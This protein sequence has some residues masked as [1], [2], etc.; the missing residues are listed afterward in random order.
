MSQRPLVLV[1]V[2]GCCYNHQRM[3]SHMKLFGF[4][5]N[6]LL[7]IVFFVYVF[8]QMKRSYHRLMPRLLIYTGCLI[9]GLAGLLISKYLDLNILRGQSEL[10]EPLASR[11]VL[12]IAYL[13]IATAMV[14]VVSMVRILR[15]RSLPLWFRGFVL[16]SLLLIFTAV[17]GDVLLR[18]GT[19]FHRL[20]AEVL[21][22]YALLFFI[23]EIS[24]LFRLLWNP[25]AGGGKTGW[26]KPARL[27][28][29]IFLSRY[30]FIL[31]LIWISPPA[32]RGFLMVLVL[33][34]SSFIWFKF[35]LLPHM[36]ELKIQGTREGMVVDLAREYSLS[37]RETEILALMLAGKN[38]REIEDEL[39]IS[40]NT[41]KNHVYSIYKKT[42]A[43][44]RFHL[45][46]LVRE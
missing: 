19:V 3:I 32:I 20:M 16:G 39:F 13:I 21:E 30:L 25:G 33:H 24:F 35:V 45:F 38:N 28:A 44:N 43:R 10:L 15:M 2:S 41:V 11:L 18:Q 40:Y 14:S 23:V 4:F 7:G 9:A 37:E 42:G 22:N 29:L 36:R 46:R 31:G 27:F 6:L 5:L 26:E 8:Q 17:G 12:L 34:G 1:K